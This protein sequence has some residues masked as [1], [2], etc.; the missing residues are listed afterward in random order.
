M[1][2]DDHLIAALPRPRTA[3]RVPLSSTMRLQDSDPMHHMP[4]TL[5][6]AALVVS[7]SVGAATLM[8]GIS[9]VANRA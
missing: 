8:W 7:T 3:A 5:R 6:R 1:T 9:I 2:N 4:P